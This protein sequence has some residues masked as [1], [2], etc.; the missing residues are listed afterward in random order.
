MRHQ[1]PEVRHV[2]GQKPRHEG[3]RDQEAEKGMA[4]DQ[5]DMVGHERFS[6]VTLIRSTAPGPCKQ[7][8]SGSRDRR[9]RAVPSP[10]RITGSS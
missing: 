2:E 4:Q 10:N 7:Q 6:F 9:N 3:E 8:V 5:L 1:V